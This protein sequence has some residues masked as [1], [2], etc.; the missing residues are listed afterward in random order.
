[1]LFIVYL[2]NLMRFVIILIKLLYVCIYESSHNV[3]NQILYDSLK[4]VIQTIEMSDINTNRIAFANTYRSA[5]DAQ[6]QYQTTQLE[7][8]QQIKRDVYIP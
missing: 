6:Q 7:D 2:V 4:E 1:M 3:I 5:Q 8:K